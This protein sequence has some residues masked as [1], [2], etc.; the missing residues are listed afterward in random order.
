MRLQADR[1]AD[2]CINR[3]GLSNDAD[4]DMQCITQRNVMVTGLPRNTCCNDAG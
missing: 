2:G 1:S 3:N 4:G